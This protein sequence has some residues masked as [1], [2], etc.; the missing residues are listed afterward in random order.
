M[1]CGTVWEQSDPKCAQNK[2]IV[3]HFR[4]DREKLNPA[5]IKE[6]EVELVEE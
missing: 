4:R 3:V 6:G 1:L 2:A 5:N